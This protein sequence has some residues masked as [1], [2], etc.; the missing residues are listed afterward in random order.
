MSS[1]LRE[2]NFL[3]KDL[4]KAHAGALTLL[5]SRSSLGRVGYAARSDEAPRGIRLSGFERVKLST[6]F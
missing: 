1:R 2:V 6:R 4:N 3:A 5:G